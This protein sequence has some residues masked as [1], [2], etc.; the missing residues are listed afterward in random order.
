MSLNLIPI[1]LAFGRTAVR[2]YTT[3]LSS[4]CK[5]RSILSSSAPEAP[6]CTASMRVSS[7]TRLNSVTRSS[8]F[9]RS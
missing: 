1:F 2:P 7:V 9:V 5:W 6:R 3:R 4:F 8:A